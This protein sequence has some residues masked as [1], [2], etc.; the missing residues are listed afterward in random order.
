MY[1]C[2]FDQPR[3]IAEILMDRRV[4]VEQLVRKADAASRIHI[5]GIG[6]S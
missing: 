1:D 4:E 2:I 5:A 3:A 6:T